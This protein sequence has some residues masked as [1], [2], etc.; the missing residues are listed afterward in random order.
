MEAWKARDPLL[1]ARAWL[2]A[3]GIS[4]DAVDSIDA[5]I[6]SKVQAIR[7]AALG[8]PF[9]SEIGAASEFKL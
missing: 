4:K 6:T 1:L 3:A 9:P 8:S 5:E 2:A 7:E